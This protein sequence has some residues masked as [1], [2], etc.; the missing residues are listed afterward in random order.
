VT[1]LVRPVPKRAGS[2]GIRPFVRPPVNN[3][4]PYT[5]K[6]WRPPVPEALPPAPLLGPK[7]LLVLGV[8]VLAQIW[9]LL[10]SRSK[11]AVATGGL[12][13]A[14]VSGLIGAQG[15]QVLIKI[16]GWRREHSCNISP[17]M[18]CYGP[19]LS[20]AETVNTYKSYGP[21]GGD[22]TRQVTPGNECGSNVVL[23]QAAGGGVTNVPSTSLLANIGG[24][25]GDIT[26]YTVSVAYSDPV[27]ATRAPALP[28]APDVTV[29]PSPL[30]DVE[31]EPAAVPVLPPLTIPVK[32]AAPPAV[33]PEAEPEVAP[34][35]P[36]PKRPPTTTPR[37]PVFRPVRPV[38]PTGTKDGAIVPKPADPVTVTNPDWH[39]PIPGGGPITGNG[40]R[41]TPEE[42]AKELG[43]LEQK[44]NSILNPTPDTPMEWQEWLKKIAD[45]LLNLVVGTTYTL[46]EDCNPDN[47]PNYKPRS[48]DFEAPGALNAFG[49]I[50][51]RLDALAAMVDQSLRAKQ[52]ICPPVRPRP[53]GQLVTVRFR[54]MA[55]SPASARKL[56]KELRYRDS[57]GRPE[58]EHVAHWLPFDWQAGPAI[59]TS[60]GAEWGIVKVWAA[61]PAE[62]RRVIRHAAA[63]AG[64]D[65]T[66]K[67][68]RWVDSVSS[69][70]RF[71]QS[72]LMRVEH[73]DEGVPCISKRD[74]PS[75]TPGWK[76]DS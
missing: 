71:G 19:E 64:V 17:G 13:D 63:I 21:G 22:I 31:P 28:F 48:W 62:G 7:E 76:R 2:N 59:V 52:Q 14:S 38:N 16:S 69:D 45:A 55:P 29:V 40:P 5:L 42:M 33:E 43:R 12:E 47:D 25:C 3:I 49:V 65:L 54:S 72:G 10:G 36:G 8:L 18:K 24:I 44:L 68:H 1:V 56:R 11:K 67:E 39:F 73:T 57:A 66:V 27:G 32:P 6:T 41:P 50:E 46:T 26:R 75:G 23:L 35:E 4:R 61:D 60:A 74:G 9:G 70:P 58:A 37:P 34:V 51:N 53:Q 15:G 20:L 30:P